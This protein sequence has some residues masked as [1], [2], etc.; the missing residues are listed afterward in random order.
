MAFASVFALGALAS[1]MACDKSSPPMEK[2]ESATLPP[3]TVC[4][5]PDGA[6]CPPPDAGDDAGEADAE[7]NVLRA[8]DGSTDGAH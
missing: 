8:A 7:G 3:I 2:V 4:Y 5:E 1:V 6:P